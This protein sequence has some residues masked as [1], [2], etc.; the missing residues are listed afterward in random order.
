MKNFKILAGFMVVFL[1]ALLALST[2][3]HAKDED[4]SG[5]GHRKKGKKLPKH[6]RVLQAQINNNRES[7]ENIQ[8]T[9]G[10]QGDKGDNGDT[11]ATGATGATG[12]TGAKGDPGTNGTNGAAGATGPAGADGSSIQG[13]KGDPGT[14]RWVDNNGFNTVETTGS[15]K[16]GDDGAACTSTNE[17]TIRFNTVTKVFE[18]CDGTK[19]VSLVPV[20]YAIGDTGPAG[21]IVFYTIIGGVHGLEAAP[22]DHVSG[23][24]WGCFGTS[25][26]GADGYAVWTGAQNTADILAGC[27]DTFA[28]VRIADAYTLGGYDDWYLP[29]KDE[30]NLLYQRRGIVGGFVSEPYWS[31]TEVSGLFAEYQNFLNGDQNGTDKDL[32]F[33]VRVIRAF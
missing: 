3:A 9:P 6:A 12:P 26:N 16:I 23:V 19:W 30:L 14:S 32:D 17:G 2:V 4:N 28:A 18:G 25:I 24:S 13:P 20:Q 7:I 5:S 22:L 21:G 1:I 27:S 8:L 33:R 10:P 11:G 29:S 31:S 15:V